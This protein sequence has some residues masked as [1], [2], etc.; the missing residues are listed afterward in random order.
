MR[1]LKSNAGGHGGP[2][3]RGSEVVA[4]GMLTRPDRTEAAFDPEIVRGLS[5]LSCL[6]DELYAATFTQRAITFRFSS[7][8]LNL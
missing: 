5:L 4:A 2:N 7:A 8:T 1:C 3:E 6:H